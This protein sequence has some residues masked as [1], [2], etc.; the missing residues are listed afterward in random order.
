[1]DMDVD[2]ELEMKISCRKLRLILLHEFNSG[3]KTTEA[4]SNVCGTT[5]K[6]I[7]FIRTAQPWF[8]RFTNG[9]FE[10]DDLPHSGRLL[11]VEM[12]LLKQLIEEDPRLTTWRLSGRLECILSH[13]SGN[14]SA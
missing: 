3:R 2:F 5:G 6:N 1:M 8:H 14:T 10:L 9:N 7:L 13:R 12:D 4:T 11:Q